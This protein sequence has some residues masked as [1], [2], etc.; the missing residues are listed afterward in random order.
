M[1][2][3]HAG[4]PSSFGGPEDNETVEVPSCMMTSESVCTLIPSWSLEALDPSSSAPV[5]GEV[6][7]GETA[8]GEASSSAA[9]LNWAGEELVAGSFLS[10]P[11][12]P[13]EKRV[14]GGNETSDMKRTLVRLRNTCRNSNERRPLKGSLDDRSSESLFLQGGCTSSTRG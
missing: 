8:L 14:K 9:D 12:P 3:S 4:K 1:R 2:A 5:L 10:T 7:Q 6:G 13:S 11:V